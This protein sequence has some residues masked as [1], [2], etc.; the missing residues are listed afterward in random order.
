MEICCLTRKEFGH[1]VTDHANIERYK[2]YL[3]HIK[4]IKILNVGGEVFG[5]ELYLGL[6]ENAKPHRFYLVA[7]KDGRSPIT[8]TAALAGELN[9]EVP[10]KIKAGFYTATLCWLEAKKPCFRLI[11][12]KVLL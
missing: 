12:K 11:S 8:T 2:T 10:R 5:K 4:A 9:A 3:Y 6:S 1:S 7:L